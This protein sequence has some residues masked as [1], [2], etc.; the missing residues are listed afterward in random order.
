MVPSAG[1]FD[2]LSYIPIFFPSEYRKYYFFIEDRLSFMRRHM[3][4]NDFEALFKKNFCLKVF[5]IH[6]KGIGFNGEQ[7]H[8]LID[9]H[10]R[11]NSVF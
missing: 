10:F 1:I 9:C 8:I 11:L 7:F 5:V 2:T 6:H 4:R 3:L